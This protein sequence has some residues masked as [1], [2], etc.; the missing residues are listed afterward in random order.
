MMRVD[1]MKRPGR[2]TPSGRPF[3]DPTTPVK[4]GEEVGED[5]GDGHIKVPEPRAEPSPQPRRR[6]L[7]LPVQDPPR[8]QSL[9]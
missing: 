5:D 2:T 6:E 4:W 7:P 8:R 9:N 1:Q 3:G